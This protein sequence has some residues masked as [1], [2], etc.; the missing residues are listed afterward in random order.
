MRVTDMVY[1]SPV[2]GALAVVVI[3]QAVLRRPPSGWKARPWCIPLLRVQR[4][5]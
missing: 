5:G 4:L 3:V 2:S 1:G